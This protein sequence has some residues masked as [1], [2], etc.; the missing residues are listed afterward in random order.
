MKT[1]IR[2]KRQQGGFTIIPNEVL[3]AKMSLRAKG[4]LCMILS[5]VDEWVVTKAWVSQHCTDGRE[6]LR[7]SFDELVELGYASMEEQGKT[8]D[9]RFAQRI[10]TFT[11][12][13]HRGREVAENSPESA[14]S[15][16]REVAQNEPFCAGS[17]QRETVD[18]N[19]SPKNTIEEDHLRTSGEAAKEKPRNVLADTLAQVCGMSLDCMTE[20]EWKRVGI[21]LAAI[22]K[23]QPD[24]TV[25]HIAAH[26]ANYRRIYRDAILTPLAL[27]NHW[28]A[29]APKSGNGHRIAFHGSPGVSTSHELENLKERL[30][31]HIANPRHAGIFGDLITSE[32]K[33]EFNALKQRYET[34][35]GSLK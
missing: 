31:G 8:E 15:R 17:R 5:N 34:L 33:A 19:P 16:R 29:T 4:L 28:G 20:G 14:G 1:I 10:W 11:D 6:A 23:A 30:S 25:E 22:R 21:A 7:A 26:A 2:V 13:P 12:Q 9:G 3:R 27:S 32:Q 35:A 24:V 18:G